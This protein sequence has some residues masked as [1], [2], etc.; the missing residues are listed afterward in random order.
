LNKT[1]PDARRVAVWL[2][3]CGCLA[4]F[5]SV[6]EAA[7][8]AA[9]ILQRHAGSGAPPTVLAEAGLLRP[10]DTVTLISIPD[11][12]VYCCARVVA[13]N[14]RPAA[15][16]RLE[17]TARLVAYELNWI[18]ASIAS[19]PAFVVKGKAKVVRRS[20]AEVVV[21]RANES[22][23][24]RELLR[25]CT[26]AEGIHVT[27]WPASRAASSRIWHLYYYLGH[28]V[29]PTCTEAEIR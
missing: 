18:P 20:K 13:T 29:E 26:S 19:Q 1:K 2:T 4:A 16:V 3:A 8:S 12:V 27:A 28:D 23:S 5:T 7:A 24:G 17:R 11:L 15:S 9:A 6:P 22:R 10:G 14:K 25:Y 21:Q